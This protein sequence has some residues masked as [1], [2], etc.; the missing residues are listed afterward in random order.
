MMAGLAA[1]DLRGLGLEDAAQQAVAAAA[2]TLQHAKAVN[3][4]ISVAALQKLREKYR[5]A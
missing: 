5:H 1:A 3:P 4:D 2:I